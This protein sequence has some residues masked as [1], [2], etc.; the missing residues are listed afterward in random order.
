MPYKLTPNQVDPLT[1]LQ[2]SLV[3][4]HFIAQDALDVF[5]S[6]PWFKQYTTWDYH[7]SADLNNDALQQISFTGS[8]GNVDNG[9]GTVGVIVSFLAKDTDYIAFDG[10]DLQV[11]KQVDAQANYTIEQYTLPPPPAPPPAQEPPPPVMVAAPDQPN[12]NPTIITPPTPQP[13]TD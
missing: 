13:A 12:S 5:A 4:W 9:G 10:I 7:L 2:N 3:A 8:M 6:L 11:I 1:G